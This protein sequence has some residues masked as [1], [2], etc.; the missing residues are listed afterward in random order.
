MRV[1]SFFYFEGL[2]V[3]RS[4]TFKKGVKKCPHRYSY[5]VGPCVDGNY[6]IPIVA[7][8]CGRMICFILKVR[9]FLDYFS[10]YTAC[11]DR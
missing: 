3:G 1:P 11:W 8:V 5:H 6:P 10:F 2:K 9:T 4:L 7:F